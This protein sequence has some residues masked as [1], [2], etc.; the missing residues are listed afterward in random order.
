M[1]NSGGNALVFFRRDGSISN[2]TR[3][4]KVI[5]CVVW[6]IRLSIFSQT[7]FI[8]E[9]TIH[10]VSQSMIIKFLLCSMHFPRNSLNIEVNTKYIPFLLEVT[11]VGAKHTT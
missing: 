7:L 5:A 4:N 3:L 11:V 2:Q 9:L 8:F 1:S 10:L 6:S